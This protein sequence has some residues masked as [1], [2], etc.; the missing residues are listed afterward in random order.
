MQNHRY[1]LQT[2]GKA[3]VV[4]KPGTLKDYKKEVALRKQF[5]QRDRASSSSSAAAEDEEH[6]DD[7]E[8]HGFR[9]TRLQ[10]P[11]KRL[12]QRTTAA[13]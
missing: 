12:A 11:P 8:E 4:K 3:L 13:V 5:A 6:D 10:D 1:I 7:E 2:A 9:Y